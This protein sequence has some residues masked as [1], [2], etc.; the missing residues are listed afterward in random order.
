MQEFDE[1][2]R[3]LI[4]I[5]DKDDPDHE[6]YHDEHGTVIGVIKDDAGTETGDKRD[7]ILFRVQLESR[8]VSD[9]R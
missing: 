2:D 8:T 7:S 4:D 9:F 6:I 5:P 3:V 1:G